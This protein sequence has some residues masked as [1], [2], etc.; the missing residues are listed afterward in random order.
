M[1]TFSGHGHL[2]ADLPPRYRSP[3]AQH[4]GISSPPMIFSPA[5]VPSLMES[6]PLIRHP[7]RPHRVVTNASSQ[8]PITPSPLLSSLF[9]PLVLSSHDVV[10]PSHP[11]PRSPSPRARHPSAATRWMA[12][13]AARRRSCSPR[14]TATTCTSRSPAASCARPGASLSLSA[15]THLNV[16]NNSYD[17]MYL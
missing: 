10:S 6:H 3:D 7:G 9:S 15:I 14:A 17:R 11:P 5:L 2:M 4:L 16:F 12:A 8:H 13:S 1:S